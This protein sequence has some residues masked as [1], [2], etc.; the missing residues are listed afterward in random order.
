M[1]FGRCGLHLAFA[2][3][4]GL[5]APLS[6]AAEAPPSAMIVM[7][8]SG[9]IWGQ[10]GQEKVSKF[11]VAREAVTGGLATVPAQSR[12]GLMAFGHRRKGDCNDVEIILHPE[13]GAADRL[14]APIGKLNPKGKG[15]LGLSLREAYKALAARPDKDGPASIIVVHDGADN[16]GQ[17]PCAILSDLTKS[18]PR[19]PVY[20]VGLSLERADAQKLACVPKL[21]GGKLIEAGDALAARA[22]IDEAFQLAHLDVRAPEPQ[23]EGE[24]P[25][26]EAPPAPGD[27]EGPPRVRLSASLAA[28]GAAVSA[29]SLWRIFK[30]D[31]ES[32]PIVETMAAELEAPLDAGTYQ[33]EVRHGLV[34]TRGPVEVAG[35]GLTKIRVP[36]NAGAIRITAKA[37]RTGESLPEALITVI[38][39]VEGDT[40]AATARDPIWIGRTDSEI[41]VPAGAY[42]VVLDDGL[43]HAEQNVTLAPAGRAIA[44]FTPA[45]GHLDLSA[46]AIEGGP[47]MAGVTYVVSEDDPDSP[48]GRREITRSAHPEPRFTLPAGTYYVTVRAG[49]SEVRER[50][51]LGPG[52]TVARTIALGQSRVDITAAIEGGALA[53]DQGVLHRVLAL[54]GGEREVARSTAK[55]ASFSLAAGR[56]KFET[57]IGTEN[58]V[59]TVETEVV[60]GKDLKITPRLQAGRVTIKP[61]DAAHAGAGFGAWEIRDARGQVVVRSGRAEAKS[62]LLAPGQY[63][64]RSDAATRMLEMPLIL[65]AGDQLTLD[66][67]QP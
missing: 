57:S 3:A 41:V 33:V 6:A 47:K 35:K 5:A 58:V 15:P 1:R 64:V 37:A 10:L 24:K 12:V 4:L 62:A 38:R 17:D 63:L 14:A 8:G 16:C 18:Q 55:D 31:S 45:L 28:D 61:A 11:D 59:A 27:S 66:L 49:D 40:A 50:I 43:I 26:A 30:S 46:S 20:L 13:A 34:V 19:I 36:L 32:A 48:Q 22:A 54:E 2:V 42:A 9:S 39:K 52:E 7:D 29:P 67:N 51:A 44:E 56:Y 21:T 65:K 25:A 23:T 53:P 60:P